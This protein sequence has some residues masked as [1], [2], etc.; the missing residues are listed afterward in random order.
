M[1]EQFF[2]H[3]KYWDHEVL[4]RRSWSPED[5][6][7]QR[8]WLMIYVFIYLFWFFILTLSDKLINPADFHDSSTLLFCDFE[9][10][11]KDDVLLLF[12]VFLSA[13]QLKNMQ[14]IPDFTSLILPVKTLTGSV[15][16][17]TKRNV[18][19]H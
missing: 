11:K 15:I 14:Q 18:R 9:W 17:L 12:F 7:Y 16:N 10:W 4:H 1:G 2:S 3:V 5:E 8:W 19:W 13:P 6:A